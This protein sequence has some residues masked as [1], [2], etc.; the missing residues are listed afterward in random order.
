MV[1]ILIILIDYHKCFLSQ[2]ILGLQ[3]LIVSEISVLMTW[4]T[5]INFPIISEK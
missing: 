2:N 5:F 1:E 4:M 3:F